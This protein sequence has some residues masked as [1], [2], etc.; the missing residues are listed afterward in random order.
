MVV[1]TG[2]DLKRAREIL[3]KYPIGRFRE[4]VEEIQEAIG[5]EITA[6]ALRSV[7]LRHE[8]GP[9]TTYCS[10]AEEDE[11]VEPEDSSGE[12]DEYSSVEEQFGPGTRL[13][14]LIK[15]TRRTTFTFPD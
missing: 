15:L 14:D 10:E 2:S 6:H 1:W 3:R 5:R 8:L 11:A 12:P 4:A 9:P 7:F 13:H